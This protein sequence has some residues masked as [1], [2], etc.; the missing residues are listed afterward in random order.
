MNIGP[1]IG[2]VVCIILLAFFSASEIAFA[3]AN[4]L[5]LK[6]KSEAGNR[7][8]KIA[9]YIT[10][11]FRDGLSTILI[12]NNL[13]NITASS[14]SAV[15]IIDLLGDSGTALSSIVMTIIILIFG[16][17]TP[18][19]IA[20][21]TADSFVLFAAYPI[22]FL[23]IV[24]KPLIRLVGYIVNLFS[25]SWVSDEEP[26]L[27]EEELVLIIEEVENEGIIDEE[28]SD[29][30]QASLEISDLTLSDIVT[31]RTDMLAIDF[32]DD[33]DSIIETVLNSPYSRLPVYTGS[34]DKIIGI[35]YTNSLLT[36]L[37]DGEDIDKEKLYSLL[38]ELVCLYKSMKLP[39]AFNILNNGES[40]MAIVTDEY[41]GTMGII[42]IEDILEELVGDIWDEYDEIEDYFLITGEN[43]FEVS[44]DL[45]IRDFADYLDIDKDRFDSRA[46]SIGG[47]IIEMNN[48]M[49]ELNET[50]HFTGFDIKI[51][52]RDLHRIEKVLL[53][54]HEEDEPQ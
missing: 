42:S 45:S 51:L 53:T 48:G 4:K 50:L 27:T 31:P 36:R 43:Q 23:M 44:G 28:A 29:L 25:K 34:K 32:E 12:G 11:N 16:E 6:N 10:D 38:S 15:I 40:K 37:A 21:K 24:L 19:T 18:K 8:A 33:M 49:P 26:T 46:S 2:I 35:L 3:A 20:K 17:T 41:G 47:W 52:E 5:R 14:I 9:L 30:L 39:E 13:V 7:R 54:V 22:S 1:Y